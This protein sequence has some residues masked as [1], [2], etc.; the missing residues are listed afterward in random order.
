MIH[1]R[2]VLYHQGREP[3]SMASVG[4]QIEG[5]VYRFSPLP[6]SETHE[7]DEDKVLSIIVESIRAPEYYT[8]DDDDSADTGG[9]AR[10]CE[11]TQGIFG[12]TFFIVLIFLPLYRRLGTPTPGPC[13]S[14]FHH[15]FH[16]PLQLRRLQRRCRCHLDANFTIINTNVSFIYFRTIDF[17]LF[18]KTNPKDVKV[19][20]IYYGEIWVSDVV[21]SPHC[22]GLK[23]QFLHDKDYSGRLT[24][25]NRNC[26]VLMQWKQMSFFF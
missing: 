23:I 16:V 15:Q 1:G 2:I 20:A 22:E 18:Y 14:H 10:T 12:I 3:I 26:T 4:P 13:P 21:M 11:I 8:L 6:Q 24:N 17:T 25:P 7:D 5:G 19:E 9:Y